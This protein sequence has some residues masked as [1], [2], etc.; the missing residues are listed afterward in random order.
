M[1]MCGRRPAP[2]RDRLGAT[3]R[4]GVDGAAKADFHACLVLD[5][6]VK[7]ALAVLLGR[8]EG[9]LALRYALVQAETV[10]AL[11]V[12][13]NV[14]LGPGAHANA[15]RAEGVRPSDEQHHLRKRRPEEVARHAPD[16]A[17]ERET[18]P[19]GSY[20]TRSPSHPGDLRRSR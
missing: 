18:K 8:H 7:G 1:P 5:A 16:D 14:D 6:R 20:G 19:D 2:V 17:P 4:S 13:W 3:R 15:G 9:L 10:D 12:E 11:L